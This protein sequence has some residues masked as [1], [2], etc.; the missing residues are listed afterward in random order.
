MKIITAREILIFRNIEISI[1]VKYMKL[2]TIL[3]VWNED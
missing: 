1:C 2:I 3:W